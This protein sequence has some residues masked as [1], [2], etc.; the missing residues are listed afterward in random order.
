MYAK[1]INSELIFAPCAVTVGQTHYNPPPA[2]WLAENGYKP[3]Y[4]TEAPAEEGY[5]AV[6]SWTETETGI[7]QTWTLEPVPDD[8]S[9][10]EFLEGLEAIL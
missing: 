3:V 9:P 8:I 1:L 6:P 4:F 2:V 5:Y 10:E 7:V